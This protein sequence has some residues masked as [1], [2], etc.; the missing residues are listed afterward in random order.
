VTGKGGGS[1]APAA[2]WLLP[3]SARAPG[4]GGA[5]YS[6]DLAVANTGASEAALTLKFLGH[7]ADGTS[8]PEKSFTLGAGKS[9]TY[10][11][12]LGSVFG[13]TEGYGA[14]QVASSTASLAVSS[15]TG[16]PSTGGGTFGQSVPAF[17]DAELIRAGTPRTILGVREDAAFR[18]NLILANASPSPIDV[19]LTLVG[20]TGALLGTK[21]YPLPPLGMTQVTRV[22]RD[23]G[24][25]SDVAGARIVLATPTGGG[26]FAAY[27]SVIDATTNDPRTLL[28]R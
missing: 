22:V 10:A 14:I 9:A 6:T 19:D 28:P 4:Q 11:D 5:F 21:R 24:V 7:D 3:S 2:T 20:E 8:G 18:T 25:G 23:L 15:Q 26:A 16:T 13:V 27:A 17:G 12:V 1:V